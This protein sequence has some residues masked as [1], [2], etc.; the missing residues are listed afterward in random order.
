[1]HGLKVCLFLL[2]IA[3]FCLSDGAHIATSSAFSVAKPQEFFD[4][5]ERKSK[6][7]STFDETNNPNRFLRVLSIS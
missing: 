5:L 6:L 3:H 4:L 7:L 2:D 1:M